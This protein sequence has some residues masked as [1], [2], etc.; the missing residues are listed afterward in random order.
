MRFSDLDTLGSLGKFTGMVLVVPTSIFILA[1]YWWRIGWDVWLTEASGTEICIHAGVIVMHLGWFIGLLG[2]I[3]TRHSDAEFQYETD[4]HKLEEAIKETSACY[5][6]S[7]IGAVVA[8]IL[9]AFSVMPIFSLSA[10]I[11]CVL[12]SLSSH[13]QWK[14][15][16][17]RHKELQVPC[18]TAAK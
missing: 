12:F 17:A 7:C 13:T 18:E 16:K 2:M 1:A 4:V 9:T 14:V 8:T 10:A 11:L 5:V 6:C 15:A 3:A